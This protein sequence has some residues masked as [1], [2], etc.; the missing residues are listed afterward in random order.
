VSSV[1]TGATKMEQLVENLGAL[2]VVDRLNEELLERIEGV[3][4][5]KPG[6]ED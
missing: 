6:P 1:I 4:G 3:L 2:D 5:N